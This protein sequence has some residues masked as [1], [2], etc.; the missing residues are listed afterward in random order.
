MFVQGGVNDNNNIVMTC[1]RLLP[2]WSVKCYDTPEEDLKLICHIRNE[3]R[4]YRGHRFLAVWIKIV[5]K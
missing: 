3:K 5:L 1:S 2:V 4:S